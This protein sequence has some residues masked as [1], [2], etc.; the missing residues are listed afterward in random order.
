MTWR[1]GITLRGNQA[2]LTAAVGGADPGSARRRGRAVT[3]LGQAGSK[4]LGLE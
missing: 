3:T 2:A 1:R 4:V